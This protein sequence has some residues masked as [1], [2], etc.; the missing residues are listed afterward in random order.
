MEGSPIGEVAARYGTSRQSLHTWRRRFE[1]EG[2][3]GLLNRSRRPRRSPSR[4]PADVEAAVCQLRRQHPRWGARRIR[5]EM[6]RRGVEPLPSRVTVHRVLVRNGLV[7]AQDQEH[8]RQYKR[9]QRAAPMHLWQMDLVGG[10]FLSDGRECKLVTGIDDH[11]RFV[12][13][14]TLVAVPSGRAVCEAFVGAMR[15]YGVP[16]EVLTDNGKQFTGRYA[17]PL[18]V[19]VLFERICRQNGITARLTKPRSPTTTGKIERF[20]KSLRREFLDH[21]TPFESFEAA[22]ASID[23][24]VN[25]YNH[26]RPH[27]LE[28]ALPIE[29]FRPNTPS[30]QLTALPEPHAAE[31][32]P[33][34]PHNG[35]LDIIE[36]PLAPPAAAGAVEFE[37]R[38]PPSGSTTL[39]SDGQSLWVGPAW[40]GWTVTVWADQRSIHVSVDGHHLRTVASRLSSDHLRQLAMRGARPAGPP[41]APPA[42]P[43]RGGHRIVPAGE[44]V[45]IE[46]NVRRDGCVLVVSRTFLVGRNYA[47]QRVI[48]RLDGHLMHAVSQ[49][50]LVATWPC[51]VTI[52]RLPA[53]RGAHTATSPLP[54]PPLPVGSIRV[55][56]RIDSADRIMV[57]NQRM[58]LGKINAGKLVTVVIE[59]TYFRILHGEEEIATKPRKNTE[60]ISQLHVQVRNSHLAKTSN[61]T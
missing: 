59:G 22:H 32:P 14:S 60:P 4:T 27:A 45:E 15:R 58:K 57:S 38:V 49:G 35:A 17:K 23:E 5:Y 30:P 18:P 43:T 2:M 11:S 37:V 51:P 55:Q 40:T 54:P 29:R 7:V 28:M 56:R 42:L 47:G 25:S 34:G 53:L 13:L 52:D 39:A 48:L 41:P 31:E 46:R 8:K 26:Q 50:V 44:P 1:Q 3:S 36:P 61:K 12:V 24:W 21:V 19:E 16:S 33:T 9:W 6:G 20:H 10:V